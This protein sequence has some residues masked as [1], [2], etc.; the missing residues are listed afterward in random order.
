VHGENTA[1]STQILVGSFVVRCAVLK[2]ESQDRISD[3]SSGT[4]SAVA[5]RADDVLTVAAA[6]EA[7]DSVNSQVG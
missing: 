4:E 6:A 3:Q 5:L 7:A 1:L 2:G